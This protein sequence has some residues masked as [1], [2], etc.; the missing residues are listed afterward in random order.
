ML[1]RHAESQMNQSGTHLVGGRSNHT[2]LTPA[3]ARAAH[4]L[5]RTLRGHR[6][7]ILLAHTSAI[8][9]AQ[10]AE[11][12]RAGAG[13]SSPTVL[14]DGLLELSQGIAE[15]KPRDQWWTPE[16]L[17]AMRANPVEHRLAPDA[18]NHR[19]VQERMHAA[20][21][22]LGAAEPGASSSP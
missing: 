15:G 21:A 22:K 11:L 7:P 9:S 18:E 8:R 12:L 4:A 6:Q 3:G 2:P 10:T 14:E 19:E 17:T 20:V 1:V 5:G 13:W 16:A